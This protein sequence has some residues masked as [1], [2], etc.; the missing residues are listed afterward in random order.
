MFHFL[1]LDMIPQFNFDEKIFWTLLISLGF[2]VLFNTPRKALWVAGFLGI[3]GFIV[4]KIFLS[5][6]PENLVLPTL[7]GASLIGILGIYFSQKIQTPPIV[8]TVPAVI[9]MVP[10]RLGYE[11]I[12]GILKITLNE[13]HPISFE[14]FLSIINNGVKAGLIFMSIALG[15]IFPILFF[16]TRT[17]KSKEFNS[18][19]S[20]K[21]RK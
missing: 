2:A 14:D 1:F 16:N 7:M 9:S 12:I 10:G 18:L 8:F 5:F 17:Y 6:S 4:K 13:N 20:K 19:F 21:K 15:I 3:L 11:F